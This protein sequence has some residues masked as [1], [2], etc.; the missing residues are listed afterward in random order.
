MKKLCTFS[1]CNIVVDH[2]GSKTSPR[3]AGHQ[4]KQTVANRKKYTHH[5]N[6]QGKNIY[7]TP[8]WRRI[9]KAHLLMNP[10]CV[11]CLQFHINTIANVVDHII[12]IE[13]GADPYDMDNLQSLCPR[14]HN[15]KTGAEKKKRNQKEKP[16]SLSDFK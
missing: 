16:L 2:D 10:F 8:R 5:I 4:K 15:V 1:G 3:C 14:H 13:D 6:E 9:R 12:E 11:T 7:H